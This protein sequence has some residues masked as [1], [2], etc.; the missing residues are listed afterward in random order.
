MTFTKQLWQSVSQLYHAIQ[1]H[2]F[3][4]ELAAGILPLDKFRYYV[5]QDELYIKA[6]ARALA[7]L[8]AKAP[9]SAARHVLLSYAKDG[10]LIE[11]Q[12]HDYFFRQYDIES[13]VEQEPAC[14]AY[15]HFLLAVSAIEPFEAGLAALLPCF[16]IYREVGYNIANT[17][18]TNNPYQLWIDTY[19]DAEYDKIVDRMLD[20]TEHAA[21]QT[22]A[23]KRWHMAETFF[24]STRLEWMF[25][26][27]AYRQEKWPYSPEKSWMDMEKTQR[28]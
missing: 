24:Q 10:L 11:Q 25:W 5:Q 14:F 21:Q 27:A 2:P 26:D 16:W 15:T 18:V 28:S 3:N 12:L 20:L 22:S 19:T 1:S 23:T 13:A 7:L 6:Y 9:D 17:S 4:R 8:A